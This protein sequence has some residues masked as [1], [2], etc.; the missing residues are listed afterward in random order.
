MTFRYGIIGVII[1]TFGKLS[2]VPLTIVSTVLCE[3]RNRL[4]LFVMEFWKQTV[5]IFFD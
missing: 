3:T 1:I 5:I 2:D 4:V